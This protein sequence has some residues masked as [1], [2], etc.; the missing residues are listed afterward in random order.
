MFVLSLFF[1]FRDFYKIAIKMS[2]KL[3]FNIIILIAYNITILLYTF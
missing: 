1:L 2:L 3:Q